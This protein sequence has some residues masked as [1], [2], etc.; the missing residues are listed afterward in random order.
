[1][2]F[3]HV[4]R[5]AG[6]NKEISANRAHWAAG[7]KVKADAEEVLRWSIRVAQMKGEIEPIKKAVEIYIEW[8]DAPRHRDVD[9]IQSSTKYILDALKEMGI[10]P[11]DNQKWVKQVWQKVVPDADDYVIVE[12][13]ETGYT[14]ERRQDARNNDKP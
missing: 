2:R 8:H 10:I 3:V 4:G 12:L 1:M 11:D 6:R 14:L 7:A 5:L 9:N 13:N